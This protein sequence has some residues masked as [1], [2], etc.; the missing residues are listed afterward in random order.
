MGKYEPLNKIRLRGVAVY[1]TFRIAQEIYK[2]KR[3]RIVF[4]VEI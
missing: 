2:F 4:C 3:I 1:L